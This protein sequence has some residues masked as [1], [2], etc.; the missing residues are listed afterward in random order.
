MSGAAAVRRAG[1]RPA[2]SGTGRVDPVGEARQRLYRILG[3]YLLFGCQLSC[4]QLLSKLCPQ[5]ALRKAIPA[6]AAKLESRR[7][8]TGV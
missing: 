2:C 3:R 8:S 5:L 4:S 1:P 6:C 7:S